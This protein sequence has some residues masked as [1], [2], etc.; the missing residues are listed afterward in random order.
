MND[1]ILKKI[2]RKNW[3]FQSQIKLCRLDFTVLN[4]PTQDILDTITSSK[5]K[6]YEDIANKLNHPKTAPKTFWTILKTFINGTKIPLIHPLSVVNQLVSDFLAKSNLFNDCFSKQCTKIYTS[7]AIPVNTRFITEERWSTFG[8]CLGEI[9][10]I[11][12]SLD[13]NKAHGHDKIA[14]RTIK[15][16]A[17]LIL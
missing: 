9:V 1:E 17:S 13:P 5:L 3:L 12:R 15:I 8:I 11:V 10:K 16:W 7:S 2:M 14:I 6:Y 4:S